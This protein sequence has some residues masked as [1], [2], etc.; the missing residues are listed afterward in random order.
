MQSRDV[1]V[2]DALVM[3][4]LGLNAI[5]G[6]VK[7]TVSG[8]LVVE[9]GD[10]DATLEL[11]LFDDGMSDGDGSDEESEIE[12]GKDDGND[13]NT[14]HCPKNGV[15]DEDRGRGLWMMESEWRMV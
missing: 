15:G 13:H 4:H 14:N 9:G 7:S 8:L 10:G 1:E 12:E 6:W 3:V 11:L 2:V 5:D